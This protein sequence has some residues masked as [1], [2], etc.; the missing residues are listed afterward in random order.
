MDK[1][2][3]NIVC[4][5]TELHHAHHWDSLIRTISGECEHFKLEGGCDGRAIFPLV[6]VYT[7]ALKVRAIIFRVMNRMTCPKCTLAVSSILIP[8]IRP[9][10]ALSC[11]DYRAALRD[12]VL[13]QI[14]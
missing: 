11:S 12:A 5:E 8:M 10:M 14:R 9:V 6:L 2:L 3:A 7:G 4:E 13:N 1:G